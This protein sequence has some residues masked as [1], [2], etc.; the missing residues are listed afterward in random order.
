MSSLTLVRRIK[1][2]PQVVFDALTTAEGMAAWWG[3]EELPVV[4]V[5]VDARVGGAYCVRFRTLD[6]REH[7][8][9]GTFLEL[10]APRRV[11]M[12]YRYALGGEAAERGRTSRVEIDLVPSAGGTELRFTHA[13]LADEAS[14]LSHAWGWGG[15]LDKLARH[16]D[17]L[18]ATANLNLENER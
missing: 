18:G 6:G 12:S 4:R 7:V 17:A 8:A 14:K 10:V 2:R 16:A 9:Y 1:A 13:E 3:P 11:V 5:E 15:A